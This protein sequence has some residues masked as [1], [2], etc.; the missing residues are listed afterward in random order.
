[1]I[2]WGKFCLKFILVICDQLLVL[3]DAAVH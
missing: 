2:F 1:M 3:I